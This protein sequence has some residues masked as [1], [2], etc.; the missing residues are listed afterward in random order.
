MFPIR[1]VTGRVIG[2]GGRT[3]TTDKKVAK[4]FN[5]P[6]SVLYNKSKVLY[7]MHL[8]KPD[9][10]KEERCFLGGGLH[11][12]DGDAPGGGDQRGVFQWHRA[13]DRPNPPHPSLHEERHRHF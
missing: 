2:F 3:L 7:G 10:V 9:I 13:D 12:R 8:A 1:D 4:Y 5:S 11:R 6:E